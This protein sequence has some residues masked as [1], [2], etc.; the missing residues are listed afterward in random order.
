MES[1]HW[2]GEDRRVPGACWPA[3]LASQVNSRPIRYPL[4][5]NKDKIKT[6]NSQTKVRVSWG[7]TLELTSGLYTHLHTCAPVPHIYVHTHKRVDISL[8]TFL[9]SVNWDSCWNIA[10]YIYC[11]R[12][13]EN[14]HSWWM[15]QPHRAQLFE[16][17]EQ[18]KPCHGGGQGFDGGVWIKGELPSWLF[19][20]RRYAIK[21]YVE[22]GLIDLWSL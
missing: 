17:D 19:E 20:P 11:A 14:T 7:T 21:N 8:F 2:R 18:M 1:W 10:I 4:S 5:K 3:S 16:T 9:G 12:C 22:L 15:T 6:P 13:W